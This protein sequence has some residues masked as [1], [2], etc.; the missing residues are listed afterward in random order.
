MELTWTDANGRKHVARIPAHVEPYVEVMGLDRAVTFLSEYGGTQWYVPSKGRVPMTRSEPA[1]FLTDS[2]CC[3]F[4]DML[5]G[6]RMT[7]PYPANF[8]AQFHRSRGR[9]YSEIARLVKRTTRTVRKYLNAGR[10]LA[11]SAGT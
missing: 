1:R 4:G 3:A 6:E 11:E 10:T 9:S 8:L 7:L 2:E 5:G